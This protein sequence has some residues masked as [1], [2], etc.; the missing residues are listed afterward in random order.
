MAAVNRAKEEAAD[1]RRAKAKSKEGQGRAAFAGFCNISLTDGDKDLWRKWSAEDGLFSQALEVVLTSGYKL[2]CAY[3]PKQDCF[4]ATLATWDEG[5]PN[6]GK[7]LSA[8]GGDGE[9][10]VSRV[11]W[12]LHWK[13]NYNMGE[14]AGGGYNPDDF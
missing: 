1:A 7:L 12:L 9:T 13:L 14:A 4:T 2:T 6:A 10:A 5:Q 8:R 11:V 3:S